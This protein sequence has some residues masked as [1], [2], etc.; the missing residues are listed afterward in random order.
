MAAHC[1]LRP[2]RAPRAAPTAVAIA[3]AAAAALL[4]AAAPPVRAQAAYNCAVRY[5]RINNTYGVQ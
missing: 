1:P 5:I 3:V 2:R 4:L